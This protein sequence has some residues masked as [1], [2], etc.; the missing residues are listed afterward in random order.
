MNDALWFDG[1]MIWECNI[2]P[3]K[4]KWETKNIHF[5]VSSPSPNYQL[6]CFQYVNASKYVWRWYNKLL[7]HEYFHHLLYSEQV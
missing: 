4:L 1:R 3:E 6:I 2:N 7:H 5:W